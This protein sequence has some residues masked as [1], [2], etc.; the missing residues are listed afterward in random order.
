MRSVRDHEIYILFNIKNILSRR[1][2]FSYFLP[3]T[4]LFVLW[5]LGISTFVVFI[6][7]FVFSP[8]IIL[9]FTYYNTKEKLLKQ[10]MWDDVHSIRGSKKDIVII[11]LKDWTDFIERLEQV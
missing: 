5:F 8:I 7:G 6:L 2:I 9:V 4:I 1:F 11:E 3:A 10:A